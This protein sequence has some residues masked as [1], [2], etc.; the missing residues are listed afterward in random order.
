MHGGAIAG[1][2][3]QRRQT[4]LLEIEQRRQGGPAQLVA[5]RDRDQLLQGRTP[6]CL[7]QRLHRVKHQLG[8]LAFDQRHR[9]RI[10]GREI[11][12]QRTDADAGPC[13]NRIGGVAVQPVLLKNVSRPFE[14]GLDGMRGTRLGR[15]LAR[16]QAPRT[17]RFG[18]RVVH[19]S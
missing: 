13:G 15:G 8:P 18:L 2:R 12:I 16:V 11:L 6:V 1:G 10:L 14:D 5:Y 4:I 3:H 7:R 17:G 9:H 19:V